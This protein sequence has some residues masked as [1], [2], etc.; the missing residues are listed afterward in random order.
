MRIVRRVR[1]PAGALKESWCMMESILKKA[2]LEPLTDA[3]ISDVA[4]RAI[5]LIK[6][7]GNAETVVDFNFNGIACV[8]TAEDTQRTVCWK[9]TSKF[10]EA[11]RR[12][13]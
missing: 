6:A 12:D 10:S 9:Y 1:F 3:N 7:Y 13:G 4:N 5:F 8:V 11:C 2:T